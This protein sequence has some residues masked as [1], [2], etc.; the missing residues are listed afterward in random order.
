MCNDH[1]ATHPWFV[2]TIDLVSSNLIWSK[3]DG[4]GWFSVNQTGKKRFDRM[5]LIIHEHIYIYSCI[6]TSDVMIETFANN[7]CG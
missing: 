2:L 5:E 3:F 1:R 6:Y 4:F 7:R